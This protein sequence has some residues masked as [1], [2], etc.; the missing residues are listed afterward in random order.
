MA[1]ENTVEITALESGA[2]LTNTNNIALKRDV[3]AQKN[4]IES[5]SG[6]FTI[7]WRFCERW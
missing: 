1:A 3:T 4:S 2:V 5:D 7:S 6:T